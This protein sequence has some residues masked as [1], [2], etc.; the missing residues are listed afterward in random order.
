MARHAKDALRGACIAQV[1]DLPLAIPAPEAVCT[2]GLITSQDGEVFNLVP[3]MVAAIGAIVA[4]QGAVSEEQQ[5]G[6]RVEERAA[7]VATEAVNMPSVARCAL[8]VCYT[9]PEAAVRGNRGR[10]GGRWGQAGVPSSKALPSSRI[11]G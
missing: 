1:L 10:L 5:V 6:V 9:G 11:W 2:E 8:S 7:S 3:T 4:D